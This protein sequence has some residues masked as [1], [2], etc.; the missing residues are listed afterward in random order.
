MRLLGLGS[1]WS[2]A[3]RVVLVTGASSGIGAGVVRDLVGRGGTVVAVARRAE[4]L[5]DLVTSTRGGPGRV[6]AHAC[7]LTR[8]DDVDRLVTNVRDSVGR[9]DV[10]VNNAGRSIR[11]SI[12]VS[13]D[14][15]HDFERTMAINYLGAV[16]LTLGLVPT[17]LAQGEGHVVNVVTAGVQLRS[18]LFSAYIASKSAL[19][20]F[21]RIM[22][23]E[24]RDQ[25]V[26]VTNV[27]LPLVRTD[28]IAPTDEFATAPALSVDQAAERVR[29][30]IECRPIA[31]NELHATAFEL[32]SVLAPGLAD[33]MSHWASRG[34]TESRA[35]MRRG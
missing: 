20:A 11:R 16:R 9:V 23:R 26:T 14:R 34:L 35:A 17:M 27:R 29:R 15:A 7:D 1:N 5:E 10:L 24:M 12:A 4:L 28:M 3:G 8:A 2:V 31:V 6:E 30:A 13:H 19:D 33:R 22:A 18:P 32:L 21:G 25:G